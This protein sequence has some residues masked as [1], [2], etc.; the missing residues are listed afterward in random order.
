MIART[1]HGAVAAEDADAYVRYLQQTGI[2][3][4]RNTDGNRGAFVLR[5]ITPQRAEFVV[6][7]LWDSE[8]AIR[9]F[10]GDEIEKA[11]FY[12]EDDRFLIARDTHVSH[13]QVVVD[14][15]L[16]GQS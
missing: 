1:W 8:T 12:P 16:V 15:S 4:F 5:R 9:Q 13:Y 14:A 3:A 7:S 10:A 6:L 11:V 2:A